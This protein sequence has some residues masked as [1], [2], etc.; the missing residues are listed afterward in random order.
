[1]FLAALAEL[2][3]V[4]HRVGNISYYEA[5]NILEVSGD[6]RRP[7]RKNSIVRGTEMYRQQREVQWVS[8][9]RMA[10]KVTGNKA[11]KCPFIKD[12]Q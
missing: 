10:E 8:W 1:M 9:L 2:G 3:N 7:E 12:V 6:E 4:L 11:I 5:N